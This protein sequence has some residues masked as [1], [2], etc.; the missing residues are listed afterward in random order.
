MKKLIALLLSLSLLSS[1][2]FA[3]AADFS[4]NQDV[5]DNQTAINDDRQS[6]IDDIRKSYEEKGYTEVP[7]SS[8][9]N[10][11]RSKSSIP[12]EV[13]DLAYMNLE[14]ASPDMQEKILE[15]RSQ[16]ISGSV[17]WYDDSNGLVAVWG[18]DNTREWGEMP[19]FSELFPG[20][21]NPSLSTDPATDQPSISPRTYLYFGSVRLVTAS[22]SQLT[23]PFFTWDLGRQFY[24]C[25]MLV[26]GRGKN[27]Q[28]NIGITDLVKNIS[29][30]QLENC[31]VGAYL[32]VK[33][34][35]MNYPRLGFRASTYESNPDSALIDISY[36]IY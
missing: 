22:G 23:A 33:I 8:L 12:S 11:L 32:S 35:G 2:S 34:P 6:F 3:V 27:K 28:C 18:N 1:I 13:F 25:K 19:T 24:L 9:N 10:I 26:A 31:N 4:S 30:A 7:K 15:A 17:S 29:V 14:S 21:D 5:P 16:I 20:W 36:D